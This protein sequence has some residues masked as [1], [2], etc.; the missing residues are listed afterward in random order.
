MRSPPEPK[1]NVE[2]DEDFKR[3]TRDVKPLRAPRR[4]GLARPPAAPIPHQTRADE[5]AA[6]AES[7]AGPSSIDDAIDSGEELAF[8]REGLSRQVLRKLRRGHWVVQDELDLHGMNRVQAAQAVGEFLRHCRARHSRC[9]RI[10][11]GK[12]LRSRN[13]EPVLK[14]KL[15]KWLAVRDEVLAFCQAPA[16]DGGA[17]AVL[18]LLKEKP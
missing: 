16:T 8:L 5:R 14:G 17:G 12:G 4:L 13:R 15:R 1:A 2:G 18:V 11:H 6:L 7:L 9:V 10:V 3:A